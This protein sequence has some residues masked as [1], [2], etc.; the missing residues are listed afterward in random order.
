LRAEIEYFKNPA[1]AVRPPNAD[2]IVFKVRSSF[3]LSMEQ[4]TRPRTEDERRAKRL[5]A[6]ILAEETVLSLG[7]I[8]KILRSGKK[9]VSTGI[10]TTRE[11]VSQN[12]REALE[13][14]VLKPMHST[15]FSVTSRIMQYVAGRNEVGIAAL[16]SG[17][18]TPQLLQAR[19]EAARLL[20]RK[21]SYAPGMAA[22]LL[23]IP[24]AQVERL[25][26]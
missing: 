14:D 4:L 21:A 7:D 23:G 8:A 1:T 22:D 24:Q 17:H 15:S 9:T 19:R 18:E 12:P 16:V 20:V 6:Y 2:D 5:A 13:V 26:A 11:E 25:A 10:E 3:G